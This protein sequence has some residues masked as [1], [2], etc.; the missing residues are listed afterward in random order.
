MI[1]KLA[2]LEMFIFLLA[3]PALWAQ[4]YPGDY[5]G[6]SSNYFKASM[7]T[8]SLSDYRDKAGTISFEESATLPINLAYGLSFGNALLEAEL[9]FSHN[10]YNYSSYDL[11]EYS[12]GDLN[13][14]KLMFNGIYKTSQSSSNLFFGGGLGFVAA[15]L[16]G[17]D[18][19]FSGSALAT[20]FMVGGELRTNDKTGLFIELKHI[21]TLG[22]DLESATAKIDYDF[23]ET[24]LNMGLRLY[25]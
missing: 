7:G 2:I 24:S 21:Y 14:S 25:F 23:Q 19:D 16:D 3:T 13:A 4:G 6:S 20:Q 15:T 12:S 9:G 18:S 22:M 1:K 17:I 11:S 8:S 10:E 5:E